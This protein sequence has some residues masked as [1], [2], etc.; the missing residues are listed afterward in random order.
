MRRRAALL[1]PFC[2]AEKSGCHAARREQKT[3]D[4]IQRIQQLRFES[5]QPTV[6]PDFFGVSRLAPCM[7]SKRTPTEL[8]R[9]LGSSQSF[10]A[11][12]ERGVAPERF[13]PRELN[14]NALR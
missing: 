13:E 11:A 12:R 9:A 14:F 10:W 2:A 5:R 4:W 6:A 7:I 1:W 3:I 8:S